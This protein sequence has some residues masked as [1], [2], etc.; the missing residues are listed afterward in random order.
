M[1]RMPC[2]FEYR[3]G[4]QSVQVRRPPEFGHLLGICGNLLPSTLLRTELPIGS[5]QCFRK[6]ERRIFPITSLYHLPCLFHDFREISIPLTP[7]HCPF[8]NREEVP[9]SKTPIKITRIWTSACSIFTSDMRRYCW[10]IALLLL[11]SSNH[12][13]WSRRSLWPFLWHY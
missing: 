4:L 11:A 13:W 1:C 2:V 5:T 9:F 8:T 3:H 6:S 12:L 10:S 7:T